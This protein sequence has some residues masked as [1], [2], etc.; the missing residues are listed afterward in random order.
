[1]FTPRAFE[2][3]DET[4]LHKLVQAYAFAPLVT[5]NDGGVEVTHL[6]FMLDGT[7]GKHGTLLAHMARAN[8][9][10]KLFEHSRE[11][12]VIFTGPHGYISPSWY[13]DPASVPTW[14]YLAV[15]AHGR[16]AMIEDYR[17]VREML[18]K[19]VA[20]HEASIEPPWAMQGQLAQIEKEQPHIVAFEMEVTRLE[21]KFKLS[22]NR[23]KKDREG[24]T[25]ALDER[26]DATSRTLAQAM[27]QTK[28]Y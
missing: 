23:S 1:M 25:R 10:W 5:A 11:S 3:T 24:V 4:L 16:P 14:N 21:G 15:H 19:R 22:Q 2:V 26:T 13:A 6:P 20:I 9:H 17:R 12:T 28:L 18:E 7:R 27:R 8:P